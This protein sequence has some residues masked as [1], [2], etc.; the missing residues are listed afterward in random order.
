MQAGLR[1]LETNSWSRSR[2]CSISGKTQAEP[3]RSGWKLMMMKVINNWCLVPASE[4][5]AKPRVQG[6]GLGWSL[7]R[8]RERAS[9]RALC[10]TV[11]CSNKTEVKT[12][13]FRNSWDLTV[14]QMSLEG[15]QRCVIRKMSLR[16]GASAPSAAQPHT[17]GRLH[18]SCSLCTHTVPPRVRL[19]ATQAAPEAGSAVEDVAGGGLGRTS[20]H[21]AP[22]HS[23]VYL[24]REKSTVGAGQEEKGQ[25][26]RA[27]AS[28]GQVGRAPR[29]PRALGDR[30]D[31]HG[32]SRPV[33]LT[34]QQQEREVPQL[35]RAPLAG[36]GGEVLRGKGAT[37]L[38]GAPG[39]PAPF[40]GAVGRGRGSMLASLSPTG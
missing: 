16:Q 17:L 31:S 5:T 22:G 39:A 23:S 25:M 15:K 14:S 20:G 24:S 4:F 9:R 3:W 36:R 26:R 19:G 11:S 21:W 32:S 37:A 28:R 12:S 2:P 10:S 6:A 30:W 29:V 7:R 18:P 13:A 27:W 35:P 33:V 1:C 40:S 8:A 38:C 34:W